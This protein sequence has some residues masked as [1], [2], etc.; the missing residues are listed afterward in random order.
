MNGWLDKL[1]AVKGGGWLAVILCCALAALL[2]PLGT[3]AHPAAMTEEEQRL[4][5]TLSRIAGAGETRVSIF[6][7]KSASAF[8]SGGEEIVGAV[9]VSRGA[10]DVGVRLNLARAAEALLGLGPGQVEVFPMEG[11]E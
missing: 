6:Y 1:R 5:A 8:S 4:S 7:A 10:G 3:A 2:T 11:S 9:I